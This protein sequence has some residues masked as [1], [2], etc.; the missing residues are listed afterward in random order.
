V[1]VCVCV[2]VCVCVCV[3]GSVPYEGDGQSVQIVSPNN[4]DELD[5]LTE[6]YSVFCKARAE[7]LC[8]M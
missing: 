6:A 7:F 1:C 3:Y 5:F 8:I 4:I 2:R